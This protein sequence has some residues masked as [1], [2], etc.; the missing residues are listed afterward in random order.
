ML[1]LLVHYVILFI[2]HFIDHL[3]HLVYVVYVRLFDKPKPLILNSKII[4]FVSEKKNSEN[5]FQRLTTEFLSGLKRVQT[6]AFQIIQF[7][8]SFI[9]DEISAGKIPMVDYYFRLKFFI[10]DQDE[11]E[12][13]L[14]DCCKYILQQL[15]QECH[16]KFR[17]HKDNQKPSIPILSSLRLSFPHLL[18]LLN[19]TKNAEKIHLINDLCFNIALYNGDDTMLKYLEHI[20]TSHT[21]VRI[22]TQIFL[23]CWRNILVGYSV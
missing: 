3:I 22:D 13:T 23:F 21:S 19:Y 8:L 6:D 10:L 1:L 2:I 14:R 9:H 7:I 12:L 4:F 5:L 20:F 11:I 16:Y 17:L 15:C 18:D